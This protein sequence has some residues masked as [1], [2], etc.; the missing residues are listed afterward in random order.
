MYHPIFDKLIPALA[1]DK[2]LGAAAFFEKIIKEMYQS[3]YLALGGS[4]EDQTFDWATRGLRFAEIAIKSLILLMIIGFVYWLL[5]YISKQSKHFLRMSDRQL[6]IIRS[7][8]RYFWLVA[9]ALAVMTQVGI[10]GDTIRAAAKA[11][12][13]AGFYYVSWAMSGQ[14]VH[15]LL[16]HY[17]INQSIE[18]L[19]HNMVVVLIVVLAAATIL[20]QFG[21]DIISIAAGLG[22]AGL[23]VGFAAQSTLAN[24]IAGVAIL[25]EQSFQVGDWIRVG[26]QEG[27][28]VRISLR[29]THILNRDNIVIIFP[30]S[31]VASSEVVNLTSKTFIRFDVPVR[32][33]LEAD[34]EEARGL[35]LTTLKSHEAVLS[36]PLSTVTLDKVGDFGVFLIVRFCVSPASV[37][38]LPIIKEQ[39]LESI[40]KTLD[41]AGIITPYPHMQLMMADKPMVQSLVLPKE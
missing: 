38:R 37:A 40:K 41:G 33:A 19:F 16:R 21:F 14:M 4:I 22:I 29:T 34:I 9:S 18:Q 13:W 24:F 2:P 28:V 11:A 25:I 12:S 20:A 7:T 23:A 6:A 1:S 31:T 27:R 30:N 15:G 39:I 32:I 35:I 10:S 5:V 36:H 26:T 17:D 3:V 8:L